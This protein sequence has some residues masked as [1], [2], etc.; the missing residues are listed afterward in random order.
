MWCAA[1]PPQSAPPSVEH[2]ERWAAAAAAG[3]RTVRTPGSRLTLDTRTLAPRRR[4][5]AAHQRAARMAEVKSSIVKEIRKEEPRQGRET[6][7]QRHHQHHGFLEK[8]RILTI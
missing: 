3:A 1:P 2:R 8:I 6:W 7:G 4:R 5:A